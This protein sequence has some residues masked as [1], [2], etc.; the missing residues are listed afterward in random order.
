MSENEGARADRRT[1]RKTDRRVLRTR[2]RLGDALVELIQEKPFDSISVQDVLDRAGV[3]RSTFYQHY[4][5]KEDLFLSDADEF[6]ESMSTVLSR[7]APDSARVAPV[8]ELFAH[9]AEARRL[10]DALV[11]SGM[12]HDFMELAEA[13][14]ARGIKLRL[15]EL[16]RSSAIPAAQRDAAARAL[17]GALL[18][19]LKWWIDDG[20][21]LQP[22]LL[23]ELYHR[24]VW[25]GVGVAGKIL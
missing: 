6:L 18:S 1:R 16:S 20:L 14:F 2:D 17:A 9:V 5:D 15:A 3:A 23:D 22:E 21:R 25:S 13:H 4:S 24:M 7:C 12:I 10:Y 11:E 8:R 19:L